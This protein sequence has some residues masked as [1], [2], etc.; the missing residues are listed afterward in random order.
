M[1]LNRVA[2]SALLVGLGVALAGCGGLSSGDSGLFVRKKAE[3]VPTESQAYM[4]SAR[5]RSACSTACSSLGS[6]TARSGA[7]TTMRKASFMPAN[8]CNFC[9]ITGTLG[10]S[11][12]GVHRA[13]GL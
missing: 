12:T 2:Q 4:R 6:A 13:L 1:K 9:A 10:T 3:T 7:T 11:D 5:E 8:A